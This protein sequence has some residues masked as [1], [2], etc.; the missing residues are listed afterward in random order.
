M[1]SDSRNYSCYLHILRPCWTWN[2]TLNANKTLH[3]KNKS[4]TYD[5]HLTNAW[6]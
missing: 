3:P 1:K 2:G 5:N 6:T 4:R